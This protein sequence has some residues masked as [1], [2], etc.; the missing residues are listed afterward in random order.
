MEQ[1]FKDL[2]EVWQKK[3]ISASYCDNRKLAVDKI[4]ELIPKNASIGLSGSVTLEELEIDKLLEER[5]NKVFNQYK[6]GDREKSLQIRRQGAQADVYLA[7]ANSFSQNGEL[8]FLSAMGNR[9][10]GIAYA[11]NVIIVCGIN[12]LTPNLE[13]ALKRA[14]EYATPLNYKRLNWSAQRPMCCQV[15]IIESEITADR[16]KVIIVG[17]NLGF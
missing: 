12:K 3:N 13:M 16:L 4:L 2:I 9:T 14:K 1:K 15:L 8:V 5:G 10:A 11:K 7:S 17:E 6:T